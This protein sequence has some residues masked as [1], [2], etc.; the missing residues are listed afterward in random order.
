MSRAA[1]GSHEANSLPC[2]AI[3]VKMFGGGPPTARPAN[4]ISGRSRTW[5]SSFVAGGILGAGSS[6]QCSGSIPLG[7]G[8]GFGSLMPRAYPQFGRRLRTYCGAMIDSH[9][10]LGSCEPPDEE[11]V[12]RAADAGVRRILTIGMDERSNREAI[13]AA[14]EHDAVF[15]AVGRHP[16]AAAGFDDAA[17]ADLRELASDPLVRAVGETGLDYY[18]DS[19]PRGDQLR[20]FEAQIAIAR[21][22][23]LPLIIH[24]RDA[25]GVSDGEAVAD[26]FELL[27]TEADGVRVILHC[28]SAGPER[29]AEAVERGWY[30]SFAGNVTYPKSEALREAA[31]LV[32]DRLLLVETDSPYL[33]PQ[34]VRG[35]RNEP[36]NVV[37]TAAVVA[38]AR[39][40]DPAAQE[41]AVEANAARLFGW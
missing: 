23:G 6:R 19:A 31:A 4:Q 12:A 34:P 28:F 38:A 22:A 13:A 9:A 29:A 5:I 20:A 25:A 18:R 30:V 10:H 36:A 21:G 14:R 40:A 17:A 26:C 39:G 2:R 27:A 16:N 33:A 32:P 8:A 35:K 1:N 37:M 3:V 24:L 11:L 41:A 7:A 15:A